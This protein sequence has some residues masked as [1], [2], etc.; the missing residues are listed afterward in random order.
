MMP[1]QERTLVYH[2]KVTGQTRKHKKTSA[3]NRQKR[4]RQTAKSCETWQC[5]DRLVGTEAKRYRAAS[6]IDVCPEAMKGG[7]VGGHNFSARSLRVGQGERGITEKKRGTSKE[8]TKTRRQRPSNCGWSTWGGG[9][10]EATFFQTPNARPTEQKPTNSKKEGQQ[11]RG[12]SGKSPENGFGRRGPRQ[13]KKSHKLPLS[14]G[15]RVRFR[16]KE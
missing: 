2:T 14:N 11:G 4:R 16:V 12:S 8:T 1:D 10:K 9:E 7:W 3:N 5:M 6:K 13:V 15:G